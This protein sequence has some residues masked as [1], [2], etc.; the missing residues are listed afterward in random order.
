MGRR[1][2]RARATSNGAGWK[3]TWGNSSASRLPN[4]GISPTGRKNRQTDVLF[5]N[6]GG[7][8]FCHVEIDRHKSNELNGLPCYEP[9]QLRRVGCSTHAS[10]TTKHRMVDC[11]E[12]HEADKSEKTSDV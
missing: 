7:C 6:G 8:Q 11:Q 4:P 3:R 12:C 5:R 9:T 10:A 2:H 1:P